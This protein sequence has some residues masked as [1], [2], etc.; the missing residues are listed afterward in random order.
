[1]EMLGSL[2]DSSLVRADTRGGEPRF[3]LLETIRDYALERLAGGDWVPA[4]DRHAAYFGALAEPSGAELAGPEQLTWLARLE[5]EHDNLLAAMSWL[6]DQGHLDQAT[7]LFLMTWRFWWLRGHAEEL[8]SYVDI[9]PKSEHL[10]PRQRALALSGTG[11]GLFASGDQAT[12][13]PLLEQS[14][15]LYRQAGTCWAQPRRQPCWVTSWHCSTR[16]RGPASCSNR[17]S[18][19]CG[20]QATTGSQDPSVHSTCWT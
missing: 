13:Q 7:R 12:A 4:H 14:L 18:P 17:R 16:T 9:L 2:V 5:T 1:M 11:F 20:R 10:P 3:S 15:P 6:A 19:R 8:A